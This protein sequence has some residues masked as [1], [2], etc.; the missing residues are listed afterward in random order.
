MKK[1]G[2][3]LLFLAGYFLISLFVFRS[4]LV[5]EGFI[6]MKDDWTIPP[7]RDQFIGQA[8]R[9]LY[10]W[11]SNYTGVNLIRS[12]GDYPYLF[13]SILASL[14]GFAGAFFSKSILVTT[15]SLSGFTSFLLLKKFKMKDASAFMGSLLYALSPMYY[16][17]AVSGYFIF[18]LSYCLLPLLLLKF[19][20]IIEG[21]KIS[22]SEI[23]FTGIVFRIVIGQDNFLFISVILLGLFYI[24]DFVLR[25][26]KLANLVTDFKRF[27]FVVFVGFILALSPILNIIRSFSESSAIISSGLTSWN[28]GIAPKLF[29][30]FFL[31]GAGYRYFILSVPRDAFFVWI[32]FG[33]LVLSLV[34]LSLLFIKKDK[35]LPFFALLS[36]I[37]V[38]LFKGDNQ[39]F[40]FF[41]RSLFRYLPIMRVAFR[42]IQYF[43]VFVSL[44]YAYMLGRFTEGIIDKLN[45]R[46]ASQ[47]PIIIQLTLVVCVFNLPFM[48][49]NFANQI[50]TVRI[51][52]LYENII[53]DIEEDPDD[54]RVL[55]LPISQPISYRKAI[56]PGLDPLQVG[57]SKGYV[58]NDG[59]RNLDRALSEEIYITKDPESLSSLF[60][61]LNIR[62]VIY[63]EDFYSH[64]PDFMT[65]SFWSM[66]NFLWNNKT[67]ANNINSTKFLNLI[68]NG[69]PVKIYENTFFAPHIYV[70]DQ[71]VGIYGEPVDVVKVNQIKQYMPLTSY[72]YLSDEDGGI[73]LSDVYYFP[74]TV[75]DSLP[76]LLYSNNAYTTDDSWSW[77]YC[78]VSPADFVYKLVAVK[79]GILSFGKE[80]EEDKIENKVW[81]SSKRACEINEYGGSLALDQK[82]ILL[83][84]L[85]SGFEE[86]LK[87]LNSLKEDPFK[88]YVD[89]SRKV[90]FYYEKSLSLISP[91]IPGLMK[92]NDIKSL[93]WELYTLAL[94][95]ANDIEGKSLYFEYTFPIMYSGEYDIYS[96][97][98]K[99]G[100]VEIYDGEDSKVGSA[101]ISPK[102][103]LWD[104]IYTSLQVPSAGNYKTKLLID[105]GINEAVTD[106]SNIGDLAANGYIVPLATVNNW[107][108]RSDYLISFDYAF[109]TGDFNVIFREEVPKVGFFKYGDGRFD[110]FNMD[111]SDIY[112]QEFEILHR[113]FRNDLDFDEDVLR[114]LGVCIYWKDG[115]C[116]RRFSARVHSNSVTKNP[117]LFIKG[118]SETERE[119]LSNIIITNINIVEVSTP[120]V[121]LKTTQNSVEKQD[122]EVTHLKINPSKY[123]VTFI[124]PKENFNLVFSESYS[125]K[126]QIFKKEKVGGILTNLFEKITGD[127]NPFETLG[128]KELYKD[129]HEKVNDYANV[130]TI[131]PN[132]L[133]SPGE[134]V[135]LVVEFKLQK[136]HYVYTFISFISLIGMVGYLFIKAFSKF[137]RKIG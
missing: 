114:D 128:K 112:W 111:P 99:P 5:S 25:K 98:T 122:T 1:H 50:Q 106:L 28:V 121:V 89:I 76:E 16:N 97:I 101:I 92:R 54:S 20:H 137:R 11:S 29:Y 46:G 39:P 129:T 61:M 62:K 44:G 47:L 113:E 115:S 68:E 13:F 105:K 107:K 41:Y 12:F 91:Q 102:G 70:A 48:S 17:A 40:P 53:K 9:M 96:D 65:P 42:N 77:P 88:E 120:K 22:I 60:S 67:L 38:F 127:K 51:N 15:L 108:P 19:I 126:W 52:P 75:V 136:A 82:E 30:S 69:D 18:L 64:H 125:D 117:L 94:A 36:L 2:K 34:F 33:T 118:V 37:F 3:T 4:I 135:S 86:S 23:L 104:R 84:K 85:L 78:S 27:G 132:D 81:F 24:Y 14:F 100:S 43:T 66:H 110:W 95:E 109:G 90:L 130:W 21:K 32:F 55:W 123:L 6:G 131:N 72:K 79:E 58:S 31:D 7:F 8:K 71:T 116:F 35:Y 59:I 119:D 45:L 134:E 57:S 93:Y 74:Q 49:G 63:R 10:A 133:G 124:N 80:A 83:E 103:N 26:K 73:S 56:H 87:M